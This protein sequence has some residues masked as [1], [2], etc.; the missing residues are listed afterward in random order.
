V[1]VSSSRHAAGGNIPA[2]VTVMFT[3]HGGEPL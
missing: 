1:G 3:A 2:P